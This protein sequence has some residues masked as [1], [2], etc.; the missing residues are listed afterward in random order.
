M[1]YEGSLIVVFFWWGEELLIKQYWDKLGVRV[2][3]PSGSATH[4]EAGWAAY[5]K[6]LCPTHH[7]SHK[8][9]S[10]RDAYAYIS[11]ASNLSNIIN[12]A[13]H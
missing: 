11:H 13:R 9:A 7:Y 3:Q 4:V 8:D 10:Y 5:A 2:L 1:E 12:L 6:T